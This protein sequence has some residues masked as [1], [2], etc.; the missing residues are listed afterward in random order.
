MAITHCLGRFYQTG[1]LRALTAARQ[2]WAIAFPIIA[3]PSGDRASCGLWSLPP[4]K[5]LLS[6]PPLPKP[7]YIRSGLDNPV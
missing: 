6:A 4:P 7:P 5:S 2:M 1:L 3:F